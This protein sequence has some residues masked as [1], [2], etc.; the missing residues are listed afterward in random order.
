MYDV[1]IVGAGPAGLA[2]AIEARQSGLSH[3]VLEKGVLVNSIYN[4]PANM[5]FFTTANLLEIGD[6]PFLSAFE[7]PKRFEGLNYYRLVVQRLGLQVLDHFRVESIEGESDNFRVTGRDRFGQSA[8]H[9]SRRIVVAIGYY[10]NP[11]F[12]GVPGEN[13]PIVH[14][15]Y[16]DPHPFFAKRVAVIGGKNS[17]AI[18][19]LELFRA[20]AQV[21]LI[22]RGE[23][24]H[25]HIKYWIMPDIKNRI[26]AGE[27]RGYFRTQVVEILPD[28]IRLRTGDGPVFELESDEVLAL[29][30]YHPDVELLRKWGLE[31][32][33]ET[34]VPNHDP[35]T[36]ETTRPGVYLA[37]S[38]VSGRN[39]NKIFIENGR[40][41]GRQIF[42]ALKK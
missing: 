2:C 6:V 21:A 29:T 18:A 41:H 5:T 28:R 38:I 4:F 17:A 13:L 23:Q 7:K 14:H 35:T 20:G 12:L 33:A 19:A 37:G 34:L 25:S 9:R 1:I 10:D 11:N 30:G 42:S 39:T 26:A 3:L 8:T 15:Y 22:Y 36:L 27:V 24:L 32:D 31:V 16:T 40:F